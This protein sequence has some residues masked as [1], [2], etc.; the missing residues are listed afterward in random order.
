M[1]LLSQPKLSP[2]QLIHG[3]LETDASQGLS[4]IGAFEH[5][6]RFTAMTPYRYSV[7]TLLSNN[8][9]DLT[10]QPTRPLSGELC[11]RGGCGNCGRTTETYSSFL[12]TNLCTAPAAVL[13]HT[14]NQA[15][16]TSEHGALSLPWTPGFPSCC[17]HYL[18]NEGKERVPVVL[19][20]LLELR[21]RRIFAAGQLQRDLKAV[22]PHIVVILHPT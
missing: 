6:W 9:T 2:T 22:G 4:S 17:R 14:A 10:L 16:R 3:H 21:G 15:T 12:A 8:C 5:H 13:P 11:C 7:S 19:P 18:L 1:Q 20:L